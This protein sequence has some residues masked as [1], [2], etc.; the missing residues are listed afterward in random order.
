MTEL[1]LATGA[2]RS[3]AGRSGERRRAAGGGGRAR[4][5]ALLRPPAEEHRSRRRRPRPQRRLRPLSLAHA[6]SLLQKRPARRPRRRPG[7]SNTLALPFLLFIFEKLYETVAAVVCCFKVGFPRVMLWQVGVVCAWLSRDGFF[8]RVR[9]EQVIVYFSYSV[10]DFL[11]IG[12]KV[13]LTKKRC[14]TWPRC[15]H[16]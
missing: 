15:F 16:F 5:D 6:A 7:D 8:M 9:V 4:H 12:K 14:K 1:D 13:S 10:F 3:A 11:L 2:G